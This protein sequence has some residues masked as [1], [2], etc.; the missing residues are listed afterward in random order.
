MSIELVGQC[1]NCDDDDGMPREDCVRVQ[2]YGNVIV[3][4]CKNCHQCL[5][6]VM[7]IMGENNE[8]EVNHE[9]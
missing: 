9:K 6:L 2:S 1:N 7:K 5:R 3:I 8:W 4:Y